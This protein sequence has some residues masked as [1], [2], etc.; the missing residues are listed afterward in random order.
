ML[1]F[2]ITVGNS[3]AI[4]QNYLRS[5]SARI[6]TAVWV[7]IDGA[8]SSNG[9]TI[10]SDN[11]ILGYQITGTAN[12]VAGLFDTTSLGAVADSNIFDEPSAAANASSNPV[13]YPAPKDLTNG[14]IVVTNAST[15]VV[16]VYYE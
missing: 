5:P 10:T 13:W 16:T 9:K 8:T 3:H 4:T 15:T 11:R 14:L 2:V 6:K 7:G 1:L 12:A